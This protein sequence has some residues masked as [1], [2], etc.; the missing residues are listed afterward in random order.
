MGRMY[1][2][3]PVRLARVVVELT[4]MGGTP[5]ARSAGA[6]GVAGALARVSG[7]LHLLAHAGDGGRGLARR[8]DVDLGALVDR[9]RDRR[10]HRVEPHQPAAGRERAQDGRV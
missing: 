10:A 5:W 9:L 2:H 7:M 1:F 4:A 6:A 3:D 8:L